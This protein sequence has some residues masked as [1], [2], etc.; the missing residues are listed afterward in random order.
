M[1]AAAA[2][3]GP[4]PPSDTLLCPSPLCAASQPPG[5][6]ALLLETPWQDGVLL[7]CPRCR[8]NLVRCPCC[9]GICCAS[10]VHQILPVGADVAAASAAAVAAAST[11]AASVMPVAS[12]SPSAASY[13]FSLCRSCQFPVVLPPRSWEQ[14]SLPALLSSALTGAS[15]FDVLRWPLSRVLALQLQL[16][17]EAAVAART[18]RYL[19]KLEEFRAV[20]AARAQQ[21]PSGSQQQHSHSPP[22]RLPGGAQGEESKGSEDNSPPL[23][24][25][26]MSSAAYATRVEQLLLH[27]R[28]ELLQCTDAHDALQ[29]PTRAESVTAQPFPIHPPFT[30]THA[31][32]LRC[33]ASEMG[34]SAAV[35]AA[36]P[37]SLDAL[38]ERF[39]RE[40]TS[41]LDEKCAVAAAWRTVQTMADLQAQ[42]SGGQAVAVTSAAGQVADCAELAGLSL[43]VLLNIFHCRF[44]REQLLLELRLEELQQLRHELRELL[45][46]LFDALVLQ[47]SSRDHGNDFVGTTG[48]HPLAGMCA[49]PADAT[50]AEHTRWQRAMDQVRALEYAA[51][52]P[53]SYRA[54]DGRA[55]GQQVLQRTI[56]GSL[57]GLGRDELVQLA[58]L[59]QHLF[60]DVAQALALPT[61]MDAPL[62]PSAPL[63]ALQQQQLQQQAQQHQESRV[64]STGV[65]LGG[66]AASSSKLVG[67]AFACSAESKEEHVSMSPPAPASATPA[68][69]Q[70]TPRSVARAASTR[71]ARSFQAPPPSAQSGSGGKFRPQHRHHPYHAR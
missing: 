1:A 37:P 61:R 18:Q 48:D 65:P 44:Q 10:Q 66:A 3:S 68:A 30:S 53:S 58:Q 56:S 52:C 57:A 64:D 6:Q 63:R 69:G 26:S 45:L 23:S 15:A 51:E 49:P 12:A 16:D 54:G 20:S 70:V 32:L 11:A 67:D 40:R 71:H 21:P 25:A 5:F 62:L 42:R 7:Q 47:V 34:I 43:R 2:R 35:P 28:D 22:R 24:G 59:V 8:I 39:L 27:F 33:I 50:P 55:Q 41:I 17:A 19:K 14:P 60:F 4:V 13:S 9:A 31:R 38:I 46:R 29:D 36:V